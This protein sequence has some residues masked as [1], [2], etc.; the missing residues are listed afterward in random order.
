MKESLA[1]G[2]RLG[3]EVLDPMKNAFVGKD[4]IIDLLGIC[5][6][7]GENLFLLGPPGT[8]KSALVHDLSARLRGHTFDYLLTR[9]TEPNELFGPFD[10]RKLREGELITNTEGM[11]PEAYLVFLD[12]LLNANSAILN[13]LLMALN[14]RVFRRGRETRPLKALMFVGA[15]NHT[16]EDDALKALYDRFLL[17]VHCDNVAEE[18]LPEVLLAG[19]KLEAGKSPEAAFGFDEVEALQG[20]LPRVDLAPIQKRYVELVHRIR[21][22]GIPVSDRRA[23]KLQNAIAASAILCGRLSARTTDL[24]VLRF[25]WETEE[26]QEVLREL[27]EQSLRDLEVDDADHPRARGGDEPDAE[28][29]A[30][31]L[32]AIASQIDRNE[33]GPNPDPSASEDRSYLRDRLAILDGRCQWVSD[34]DK[35]ELLTGQV[36]DLWRKLPE[37]T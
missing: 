13:S 12:E 28:E 37:L 32:A 8:A 26:Q 24:W 10:I 2:R 30:R 19:W 1:Y 14:E 35:R 34:A 21:Q 11:L 36:S 4:E 5:L 18:R 31:E 27:V 9:F 33:N 16:P 17:R 6:V 29:L 25:T 23:V 15:S 3:T 7:G 20:L 22:A